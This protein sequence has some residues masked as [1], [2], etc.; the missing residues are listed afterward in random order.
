MKVSWDSGIPRDLGTFRLEPT[1]AEVLLDTNSDH[2]FGYM[3]KVSN[4]TNAR[5]TQQKSIVP[6]KSR[7]QPLSR[8][9][10]FP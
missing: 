3:L 4:Y 5:R 1:L 10:V 9:P 2:Y 8:E 6:S 7:I